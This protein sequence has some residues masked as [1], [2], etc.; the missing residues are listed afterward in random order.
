MS[1]LEAAPPR[2]SAEEV[3]AIA[4]ELFGLDGEARDLGSERDQTFLVGDGVLKISNTGED[5]TIIDLEAQALAH[6]ERVDPD[7]PIARQ[8][9]SAT[10]EGHF[11]RLF[12][13][14]PGRSGARDLGHLVGCEARRRRLEHRHRASP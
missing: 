2:F 1:V 6:I 9:G 5:P 11:V 14:M 3:A 4:A 12:E 13:R 7:L 10:Y 8:R